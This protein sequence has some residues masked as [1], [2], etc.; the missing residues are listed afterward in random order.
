MTPR[1][2]PHVNDLVTALQQ[3]RELCTVTARWGAL[4]AEL[5][6]SGARVLVA[7][8]G[9]SAAQAQHF[10][11]ELVGRYD[12]DRRPFSAL[13]LHAET[14]SMTAI[15]NDYGGDEVFAR[16]VEA[17]GRPGD[18]CLLLSTSGRSSN[19]VAAAERAHAAGLRV[20]AMTGPRPNPLVALSDD[21]LCIDAQRTCTIQ[22][23]HLV[24][25]HL[26]CEA[27]DDALTGHR[28]PRLEVAAP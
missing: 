27:L 19:L 12:G 7:G 8:N 3:D 9:G 2:D 16:Q 13:A 17:H 24:A 20:W 6:P 25:V 28:R 18:V 22:E 1:L 4:L 21:W 15:M 5:L 23:I 10:T 11:A 26:V 14:S